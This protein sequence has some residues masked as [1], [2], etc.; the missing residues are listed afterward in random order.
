MLL[1][2]EIPLQWGYQRGVSLGNRYFTVTNSSSVRTVADRHRLAAYR[3]KHCWRA[4]WGYQHRRPWNPK[5]KG[6]SDF[7][8]DFRLQ[9]AFKGCLLAEITV[10][11]PRQPAYEIT[12][13]LSR[14][15]LIDWLIDSSTDQWRL[16]LSV[17]VCVCVLQ[18]TKLT[19]LF[20]YGNK[21]ISLPAELGNLTS[22]QTLALSENS[23][24]SLPDTLCTLT[25]LRI[26]DL[27]HNKLCEVPKHC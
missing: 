8:C 17:H 6:F 5:I 20:L 24:Q 26:L 23:L 18:L 21:L 7:F 16:S 19:E 10:D 12:L 22:L 13:M 2:E 1:G 25:K 14:D 4:F 11:R 27:R 9:Y 3:N 15:W